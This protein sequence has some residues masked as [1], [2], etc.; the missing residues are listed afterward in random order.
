MSAC[1]WISW[2]HFL[3]LVCSDDANLALA[4]T[5]LN[6]SLTMIVVPPV[7]VVCERLPVLLIE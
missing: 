4:G 7:L 3:K 6:K 2:T 5:S 1:L